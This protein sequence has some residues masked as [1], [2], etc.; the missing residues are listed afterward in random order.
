LQ[1]VFLSIGV[2]IYVVLG[3]ALGTVLAYVLRP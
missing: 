3:L 2:G 1:Y